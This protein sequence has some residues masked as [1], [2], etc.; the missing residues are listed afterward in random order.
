MNFNHGCAK[1]KKDYHHLVAGDEGILTAYL[2]EDDTFA[3]HFG[4]K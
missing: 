3:V 1:L 4:D 2:P